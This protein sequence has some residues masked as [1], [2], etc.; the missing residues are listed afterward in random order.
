MHGAEAP[1]ADAAHREQMLCAAKSSI[2]PAMR[3]DARSQS[4]AYARQLLQLFGRR[5][6]DIYQRSSTRGPFTL[7]A[8][9]RCVDCGGKILAWHFDA[10]A[11]EGRDG[12]QQ[13]EPVMLVDAVSHGRRRAVAGKKPPLYA[14]RVCKMLEV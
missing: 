9:L 1:V 14:T 4:T 11:K 12:E 2:L 6:V 13:S 5:R 8:S 10:A 3:D 7:R